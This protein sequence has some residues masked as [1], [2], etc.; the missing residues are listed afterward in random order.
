MGHGVTNVI[1]HCLNSGYHDEQC[2]EEVKDP[3]V[4]DE[5]NS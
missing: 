4:H 1:W 2:I 3:Y 5:E